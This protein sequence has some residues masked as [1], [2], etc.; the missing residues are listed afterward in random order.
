MTIDYGNTIHLPKTD[1]PRRAGLAQL[2]PKI[3]KRW[4]DM[5]L[6]K[7]QREASKDRETFIL[8]FGPP[9]ANGHIHLGHLLS[10]TLKD[11]VTR[12]QQA[13]GKNAL[14][15]PGWDCHGLPIEWKIEEKYRAEGKKKN[16]TD[17]VA[18][19]AEC[20]NFAQGWVDV[21][22]SEFQRVGVMGDWKNYYSTM[23]PTS[24]ATIAQE[25]HKFLLN[26]GLYRGSKP[27]M[28]SIPEQ[29]ALAEAEV[30]YKDV[31]SDTAW[32][33]FPVAKKGTKFPASFDGASVVI[34]TTTPWTLPGNRAVA[35]GKDIDYI[36][37]T[38]SSV[39]EEALVKA[40]D[41]LI[42][43][44]ALL[45]AFLK[46]A[47]IT[48]STQSESAKGEAFEGTICHHALH[49]KGYEFDVPM[50]EGDFV[51]TDA[52]TGF[53]HIAPGHGE[54]DYR[55]GLKNHIEVPH[56]VKGDGTYF[57][58]VP[59]FAGIP[60]YLPDG[61]KGWANKTVLKEITE[62][63]NLVAKAQI[64][65]SYP[66][67]WRSKAPVIFRNTPQWFISME[68]NDL[69]AKA[70]SEIKKT[71]WI[72][73]RGENRI[74]AMVEQ[75][76]DWC[77]S[78]QR[79]WGV[80][81]AIFVNKKTN[82][83]L[84]DEKVLKNIIDIFNKEGSDAWFARPA[85][86]FLGAG[87]NADDFE[88]VKDII[89]VWFESGSTQGFVLENRPD[90]H[91]P[92]DLYLEGSDQHRGWFQSS[93]LV[94]CGTRGDA[95][96]KAVLTHGFILDEKGYKMSKSTGNVTSPNALM[97][98]YGADVMRLWVA[99]SD[100]TEDIKFGENILSGHV[101][102]YRRIRNTFCYLLGSV[103]GFKA[104]DRLA[105]DKLGDFD[106]W[107]LHRLYE[108][109]QTVR[110]C[111]ND[112]DFLKLTTVVHNFCARDLSAFYFDVCKDT[113]YCEATGSDKRR[114]VLTV[115]DHVFNH[116]VHWLSPVLVYTTE[117][118]WL[119]YKGLT[120]DDAKESIHLSTMPVAPKEWLNA[121]LAVK[122]D[123]IA[124][125]RGVVTGA[126]EIKRAEKQI[127]ASLEASPQVFVADTALAGVLKSISFADVC[128]TSGIDVQHGAAPAGAFTLQ[129]VEGVSVVFHKAEGAKCERC[130]RYTGDV[131][132]NAHHAGICARCAEVVEREHKSAAA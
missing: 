26:G 33:K 42:V 68:K 54:D 81:I 24:E 70:L 19:R 62:S 61:K 56:T 129:G 128:I 43:A 16:D 107:V 117:E 103:T 76:G 14:L 105:Y 44:S 46:S 126:L 13:T 28:W 104:S 80:P 131:G 17:A 32:V 38:V 50:L 53:V 83:P 89:D 112:F 52:G 67:S 39:G 57:E 5:D 60:V 119:S 85:S 59:L 51:T 122:W 102:I 29:T 121:D 93:L 98:K 88:Q 120:L 11:F 101:D 15:V 97:E 132:S 49:G 72:P 92:A 79:A 40:G 99:G 87:Y 123:K 30:E 124:A 22:N 130:W 45:D 64:Q 20:R 86:D 82:E 109:D 9:F 118:A 106:K 27:V 12:S 10:K 1:F 95:P 48:G 34:W 8:H 75:R 4:A 66:H 21:Q 25:I 35:Y 55:L 23:H 84:K 96:F 31:T 7:K 90:L 6:Y 127:G 113:L 47:K 58:D 114:G 37:V 100:Y 111:V 78:R 2:E 36:V 74:A 41:K 65:H 77:V 91:R 69:R 115:L 116:L 18:F 63:G 3:Q 108:I 71:R 125:V 94:G 110:Q 73:A